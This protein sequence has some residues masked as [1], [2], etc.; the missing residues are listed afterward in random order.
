MN[1]STPINQ[2]PAMGHHGQFVNEQ[3]RQMVMQAQSAVNAIP[4]PQ[5]T[6]VSNDVGNDDDATIQEVLNQINGGGSGG[7]NG[8][9]MEELMMQQQLQ[10]QAHQQEAQQQHQQQQMMRQQPQMMAPPQSAPQHVFDPY[11]G[12][13]F[14]GQFPPQL[15]PLVDNQQQYEHQDG[16]IF[17]FVSGIAEDI[18]FAAFVFIL[19]II[20]HFI[21]VDK[22]LT[23]YFALEKIPYYDIVLK[24]LVAFVVVVLLRKFIAK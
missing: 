24:A 3:Q 6:Q 11:Q 13:Q 2:L 19:F 20:V 23:R 4:M 1:K 8:P 5:N 9:S 15:Q 21:P 7:G 22:F 16:S 18:K 14:T 17:S 10:E 12:N